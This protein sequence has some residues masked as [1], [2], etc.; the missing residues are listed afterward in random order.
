M[1]QRQ[2]ADLPPYDFGGSGTI[3]S[4]STNPSKTTPRPRLEWRPYGILARHGIG[5]DG[6]LPDLKNFFI[7]HEGVIGMAD[8]TLAEIGLWRCP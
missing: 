3:C 6:D 2:G 7:L 5:E 1:G 4:R 8:G